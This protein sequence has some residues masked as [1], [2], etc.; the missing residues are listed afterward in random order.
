MSLLFVCLAAWVSGCG[1]RVGGQANCP[2]WLPAGPELPFSKAVRVGSTIY[3]SG[4]LGID[5]ATHTLVEGGVGPQT[6]QAIANIE[7]TLGHFGASLAN[8]VRCRVYMAQMSEWPEMNIAYTAAMPAPLP[9]RA[10]LGGVELA[11][12]ARLELECTA[13]VQGTRR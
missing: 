3:L 8:L 4:E 1:S 11:L 2:E 10:A 6:R 7:R 13:V 5:P 9:A 12:G